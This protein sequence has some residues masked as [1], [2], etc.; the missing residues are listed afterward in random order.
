[1]YF[2]EHLEDLETQYRLENKKARMSD[3][4]DMDYL[5]KNRENKRFLKA[6]TAGDKDS[7]RKPDT[8]SSTSKSNAVS[9]TTKILSY[10]SSSEEED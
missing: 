8:A 3:D 1:M 5:I 2:F 10:G 4:L 7:H 9:R 6:P